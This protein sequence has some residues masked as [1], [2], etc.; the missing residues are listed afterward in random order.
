MGWVRGLR[1]ESVNEIRETGQGLKNPKH[2]DSFPT[3]INQ[4]QF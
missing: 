3:D 2:I 4:A 1:Y